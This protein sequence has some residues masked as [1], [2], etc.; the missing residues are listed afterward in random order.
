MAYVL[1]IAAASFS[2]VITTIAPIASKKPKAVQPMAPMMSQG[3][4][5]VSIA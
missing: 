3:T 2:R 1:P 4:E 5:S